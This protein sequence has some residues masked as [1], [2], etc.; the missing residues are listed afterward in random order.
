V[1]SAEVASSTHPLPA[2]AVCIASTIRSWQF[3]PPTGGAVARRPAPPSD[4][5]WRS[6]GK[7]ITCVRLHTLVREHRSPRCGGP[8]AAPSS[9]ET[10]IGEMDG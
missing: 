10:K 8:A 5:R 1:L 2:V 7:K 6:L 3:S 9:D 4:E